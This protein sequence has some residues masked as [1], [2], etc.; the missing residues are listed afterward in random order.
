MKKEIEPFR[1]K[2]VLIGA[3]TPKIC[4]PMVG[5]TEEDLLANLD[6]ALALG[7][8]VV[9]WRADYFQDVEAPAGLLAMLE[10]IRRTLPDTPLL[11]TCRDVSEGGFARIL[12]QA[13]AGL[14]ERAIGSGM[15]DLLDIELEAARNGLDHLIP[16][17]RKNNIGVVLSSHF[18]T[19]TPPCAEMVEILQAE[20]RMGADIAKIAVMPNSPEDVLG[21]LAAT[22]EMHSR[23]AEIPLI[24]MSMGQL[25][26]PSRVCGGVFGNALTFGAGRNASAPGQIGIGELRAALALFHSQ[27]K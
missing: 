27:S 4:M 21:L 3:G 23:H 15:I 13:R 11:F 25:G 24:T 16:L 6:E 26:L 19:K 12:P 1:A 5:K 9:E 20:Q 10:K 2:S 14:I 17:A 7:P 8:D 22:Q 18:F